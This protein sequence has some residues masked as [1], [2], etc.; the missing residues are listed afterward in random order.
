VIQLTKAGGCW[1]MDVSQMSNT[2]KWV[3]AFSRDSNS[4]ATGA[5]L[6]QDNRA[7]A[8]DA[9]EIDLMQAFSMT[10]LI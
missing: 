7:W 4:S 3:A 8:A 5:R 6:L 10:L 2:G 9:C 1:E